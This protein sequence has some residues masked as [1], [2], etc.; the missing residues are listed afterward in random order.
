MAKRKSFEKDI[1]NSIY[2]HD[3]SNTR[4]IADFVGSSISTAYK[5]LKDFR[6]KDIVKG[7]KED[8]S[9][10]YEPV[11]E[12]FEDIEL[13]YKMQGQSKGEILDLDLELTV[14]A[15][16]RTGL[17]ND[18]ILK[19]VAEKQTVKDKIFSGLLK[20]GD[21]NKGKRK[22]GSTYTSNNMEHLA[23]D[24]V[25]TDSGIGITGVERGIKHNRKKDSVTVEGK[26]IKRK[27]SKSGI[28][29]K[30]FDL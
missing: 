7:E 4:E 23:N 9:W 8:G 1:L 25:F 27:K 16:V 24:K 20:I 12:S 5:W 19:T 17:T 10:N 15:R 2:D 13:T 30:S 3:L 18:E 28:E 11:D 21:K 14:E 6:D 29:L 22:D 26:M